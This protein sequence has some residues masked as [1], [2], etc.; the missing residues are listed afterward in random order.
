MPAPWKSSWVPPPTPPP[1]PPPSSA[2]TLIGELQRRYWD[3][4]S[5]F[6]WANKLREFD[7]YEVEQLLNSKYLYTCL[8]YMNDS[9]LNSIKF[10]NVYTVLLILRI[11][12]LTVYK[13]FF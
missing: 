11:A 5:T 12:I 13:Q 10:T 9:R 6:I 1:P 7:V 8:C 2:L 4:E 3:T